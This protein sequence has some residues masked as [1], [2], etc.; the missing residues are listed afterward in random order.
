M[1]SL[2][3]I[4]EAFQNVIYVLYTHAFFSMGYPC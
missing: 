4:D 3:V 1:R 2:L